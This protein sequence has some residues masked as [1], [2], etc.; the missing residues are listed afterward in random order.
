M[1]DVQRWGVKEERPGRLAHDEEGDGMDG[2]D[3]LVV[4]EESGCR[5]VAAV[6]V[7]VAVA[8]AAE[9]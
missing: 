7:A 3:R 8:T 6:V 1:L 4:V 2:F 5:V 9:E